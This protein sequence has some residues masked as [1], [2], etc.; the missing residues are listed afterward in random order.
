MKTAESLDDITHLRRSRKDTIPREVAF[1]PRPTDRLTTVS[2]F[3][4]DY[5]PR[6]ENFKVN[7]NLSFGTGLPFG[8][9]D[10]NLI[11]RN[12]Y[13][14]RM[15]HRV[16]LGFI[17]VLWDPNKAAKSSKKHIFSHTE[18][19]NISL[20]VFNMLG[21]ANPASNTWIKTI[22]N[23]QYAITNNLTSRRVNLRFRVD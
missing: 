10:D 15:Y 1:V 9:K 4:Q 14:F 3:F 7:L 2:L 17:Y 11:Y 23:E 20:E 12:T 5:L 19:A 8:I 6:N 21:V 22:T 13:R 16:D 18:S